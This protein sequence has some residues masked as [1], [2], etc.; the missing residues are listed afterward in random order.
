MVFQ[1]SHISYKPVTF[2]DSETAESRDTHCASSEW[3]LDPTGD[4][5]DGHN[6]TTI[7]ITILVTLTGLVSEK[8]S[9]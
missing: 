9:S 5:K 3:D 1:V 2:L 8:Y 6:V 7:V 4:V